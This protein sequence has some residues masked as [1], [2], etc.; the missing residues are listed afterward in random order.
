MQEVPF[1]CICVGHLLVGKTFEEDN[2]INFDPSVVL[3]SLDHQDWDLALKS[4]V[5]IPNAGLRLFMPL[6]RFSRLHK[7][8]S[9]SL[10]FWQGE[11]CITD[12]ITFYWGNSIS[13]NNASSK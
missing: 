3:I 4:P 13:I 6:T 5:I 10:I 9:N 7:N 2:A 8:E 11:Q 1:V 12:T